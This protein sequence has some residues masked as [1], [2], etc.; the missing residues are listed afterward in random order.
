MDTVASIA[1]L[2]TESRN[3]SSVNVDSLDAAGIVRLMNTQ[4]ATIAPIVEA[5]VD[6][7]AD[8][9]DAVV[10]RLRRGGRLIFTG[11]GTSGRLGVLDVS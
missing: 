11:A 7:I 9:M 10:S 6:A 3:P 1:A 8:L 2:A 4:D 5:Q